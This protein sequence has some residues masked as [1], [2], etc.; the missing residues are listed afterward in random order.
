MALSRLWFDV[1]L[2]VDRVVRLMPSAPNKQRYLSDGRHV[3][4]HNAAGAKAGFALWSAALAD[5]VACGAP[6]Q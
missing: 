2:R 4:P 1:L 6:T 5:I 3:S